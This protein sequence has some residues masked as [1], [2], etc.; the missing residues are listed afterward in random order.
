MGRAKRAGI[1][2]SLTNRAA[3]VSKRAANERRLA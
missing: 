2:R 1:A 3:R